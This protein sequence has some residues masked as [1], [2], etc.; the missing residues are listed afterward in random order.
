M[1]RADRP[2]VFYT[3]EWALAVCRAYRD[4]LPPHIFFAYDSSGELCGV[5]ALAVDTQK[6]HASFLCST[7]GDYCD[8]ISEAK[9]RHEFVK[10][11][12]SELRRLG[13]SEITLANL[14]AD[15]DTA[16]A[17][18]DSS[19]V[20]GYRHFSRTGYICTQVNLGS[21]ERTKTGAVALPRKKMLRHSLNVFSREGP[22]RLDHAC[23]AEAVQKLLPAFM[24]AHVSRFVYTGRISNIARNARRVFLRE[25]SDLLAESHSVVLTRMMSGE[26]VLAWNYGFRFKGTWFWYQP[27][28]DS[29]Y[30]KYSPGFCLLA[31]IVE[32][33]S[34]E[35]EM[36]VVDLGLGSEE[37][38]DRFANQT[39]EIL[40]TTLKRSVVRHWKEICRYRVTQWVHGYPSLEQKLRR[41]WDRAARLR[42]Q[43]RSE[44][45]SATLLFAIRRLRDFIWCKTEINLFRWPGGEVRHPDVE[46]RR[47]D[48]DGL[49]SA[50]MQYS[51]D[52][53][54]LEYLLGAAEWLRSGRAIGYALV[55][56]QGAY[57]HFAFSMN[58]QNFFLAEIRATLEAP[59]SDCAMIF[60]CWT[61][62]ALRRRKYYRTASGAIA[63]S[64][65][66]G[67]VTPWIFSATA[68]LGSIR[69]IQ[70]AGFQKAYSLVRTRV[71]G[72]QWIRRNDVE[73]IPAEN[74]IPS[75]SSGSAA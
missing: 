26:T 16:K 74:R 72:L 54:T 51:D 70:E 36:Q 62:P 43:L 45:S 65:R 55:D 64:L 1:L 30:E 60:D 19:I 68:N 2:Q 20:R 29:N 25:L 66:E 15:S 42:Q 3:Y 56:S 49:A 57:L 69:G 13:I 59:S 48:W 23:S 6:G 67:G 52:P 75:T 32:E 17:L 40:Y 50:V 21:L 61:P 34:G 8:F 73:P 41:L 27:T 35:A 33:A 28:F 47:L 4:V 38:K 18:R 9:D 31:K 63:R 24:H 44:G 12:L 7:T 11:V 71:L 53:Q 10:A 14:P 5:A 46:L 22:V 37:Y 39:R 58:F